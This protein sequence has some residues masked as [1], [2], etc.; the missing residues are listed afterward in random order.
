MTMP[1]RQSDR[2]SEGSLDTG[3][4]WSGGVATA[5]VA[6]LVALLGVL[7]FRWLFHV[8]ILAP[9][10]AGAYGDANTTVLVFAT[11]GVALL[12]T[13]LLNLLL[14][15]TPRPMIF[16]WITGLATVVAVIFPFR[17]SAPLSQKSPRRR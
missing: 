11:A 13:A 17:T 9:A 6:G 3:Q 14:L 10:S 12:A 15:A 4:L 7:A 1:V 5:V 8:P 16:G 2:S